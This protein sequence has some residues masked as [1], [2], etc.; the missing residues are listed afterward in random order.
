MKIRLAKPRDYKAIAEIHYF[1]RRAL[2]TGF[3]A[4]VPKAF[5][6][7][8]YRILLD[9]ED[10]VALC[11]ENEEKR[12]CG[13]V[14]AT[15]AAESHYKS[16]RQKKLLLGMS[17]LSGL[18][19]NPRLLLRA[20]KRYRSTQNLQA[21]QF[22]S[23]SGARGEFWVWDTRL[24][25]SAWAVKLYQAHLKL[26]ASIGVSRLGIEVDI[27]NKRIL[28]F[29]KKN[30]ARFDRSVELPD[31]RERLFMFYDFE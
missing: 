26:L 1:S 7:A 15:L 31:G 23:L 4:S 21:P 5:L 12:I 27:E 3:F 14:T 6:L 13:F 16:L 28:K 30:G 20:Y 11:V 19:L 2:S 25:S 17:L 24:P 8:Y 10:F 9:S 29:H 22:V 18:I